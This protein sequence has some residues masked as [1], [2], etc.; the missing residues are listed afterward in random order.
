MVYNKLKRNMI[1]KLDLSL[2]NP[3]IKADMKPILLFKYQVPHQW[4]TCAEGMLKKFNWQPRTHLSTVSEVKQIDDDTI[5]F[6][7]RHESTNWFGHTWEQVTINRVTKEVKSEIL[8]A[9]SDMSTQ[10]VERTLIAEGKDGKAEL[11]A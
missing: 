7:R 2:A 4:Q 6:Y 1:D 3:E 10:C 5:S 11:S 9:N 8:A